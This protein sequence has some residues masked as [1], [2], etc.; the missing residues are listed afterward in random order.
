MLS[1]REFLGIVGG[2]VAGG[3]AAGL[4]WRP[5]R[6]AAMPLY[7]AR[8]RADLWVLTER[9]AAAEGAWAPGAHGLTG[10]ALA[11]GAAVQARERAGDFVILE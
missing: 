8:A 1:R 9:V 6:G 2:A 5:G 11:R 7:L 10:I 3:L 4:A